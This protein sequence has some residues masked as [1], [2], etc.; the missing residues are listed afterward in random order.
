M[1]Q[2]SRRIIKPEVEEKIFEMFVKSFSK[3]SKKQDVIPF[4]TDLFT[5]TERIMIAKR[6]AIAFLLI[7]GDYDQRGIARTLKVSTNTVARI[8]LIL[9]TQG[10]GYKNLIKK[11]LRDEKF[12]KLLNDLFEMLDS[13]PPKGR[14]WSEWQKQRRV[15][16]R[17]L[18]SL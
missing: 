1:P 13:V 3:V 11:L 6:I 5:P 10:S 16:R 9:K 4:I 2:V 14:N 8:N 17:K 18:R 12:K 7:R 15:R